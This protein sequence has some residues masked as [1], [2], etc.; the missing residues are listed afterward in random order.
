[1]SIHYVRIYQ[2]YL[3]NMRISK[4]EVIFDDTSFDNIDIIKKYL[5]I[6]T[7]APIYET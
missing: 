3:K 4:K 6:V 7:K 2:K 5:N 1:M